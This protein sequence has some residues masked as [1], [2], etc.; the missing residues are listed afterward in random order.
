[1]ALVLTRRTMLRGLGGV[2]VGL[3]VLECMLDNHGAKT[4]DTGNGC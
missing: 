4:N 1:M 3:P 2:L